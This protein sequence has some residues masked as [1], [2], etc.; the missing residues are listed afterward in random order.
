MTEDEAREEDVEAGTE[1]AL[2]GDRRLVL[3]RGEG[4]DELVLL[5]RDGRMS[6]NVSITEAGVSLSIGGASL[7]LEVERDLEIRADK[8]ALHGRSDLSLT[9]EGRLESTARSVRVET[10]HGN[11]ELEANDDVKIDGERVLLNC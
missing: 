8:I 1:L 10:T 6:V 4:R 11:I 7:A 2:A 3:R 5:E 9:T